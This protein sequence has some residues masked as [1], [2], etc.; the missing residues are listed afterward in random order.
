VIHKIPWN[1]SIG[2]TRIARQ[3]RTTVDM[4]AERNMA[5]AERAQEGRPEV[6]EKIETNLSVNFDIRAANLNRLSV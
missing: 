4:K 3:D 5:R 2:N 6:V 1:A